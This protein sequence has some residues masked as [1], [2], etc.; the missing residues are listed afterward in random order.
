MNNQQPMMA[1]GAPHQQ[2]PQVSQQMTIE[3]RYLVSCSQLIFAVVPENP[4]YKE[5]V[6]TLLFDYIKHISGNEMAPK[7]TGMLIDLPIED[8][9][10]IMQDWG[11]LQTRVQQASDMLSQNQAE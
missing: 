7:I 6:G 4:Q 2:P 8:I 3:Q 5:Q 10:M 1:Q 11:L 9:K